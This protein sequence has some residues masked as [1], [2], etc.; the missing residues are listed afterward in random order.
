[1]RVGFLGK[2]IHRGLVE[3]IRAHLEPN[4][5][6]TVIMQRHGRLADVSC[7]LLGQ[8][9]SFETEVMFIVNPG[10]LLCLVDVQGDGLLKLVGW[11][12]G[13]FRWLAEVTL[14]LFPLNNS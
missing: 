14:R 1:M 2:T 8:W 3:C 10:N 5:L 7:R 12:L 6:R 4:Q 9:G 13:V 11:F